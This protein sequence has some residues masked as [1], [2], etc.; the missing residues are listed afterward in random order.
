MAIQRKIR[1]YKDDDGVVKFDPPVLQAKPRDQIFWSN[2]DD[3]PHWPVLS[4]IV[5]DQSALTGD[6]KRDFFMTNQIAQKSV[7]SIFA[8]APGTAATFNYACSI[9]SRTG[10]YV[11]IG[12]IV[13]TV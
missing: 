2:E 1:I 4:T 12:K 7:S 5:P 3:D 11:E 9:H 10:I 8:P 13:V 6:E